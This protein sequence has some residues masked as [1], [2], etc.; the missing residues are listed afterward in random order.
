[1]TDLESSCVPAGSIDDVRDA[2]EGA[3]C[4]PRD[5]QD[6][7]FGGNYTG[8]QEIRRYYRFRKEAPGLLTSCEA[9]GIREAND[10]DTRDPEVFSGS[11][12]VSWS[13]DLV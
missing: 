8:D 1:V 10:D 4:S 13:S 5:F 6:D 3:T 11:G 2:R 9:R 12:R 7:D